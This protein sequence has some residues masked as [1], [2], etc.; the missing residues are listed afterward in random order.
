SCQGEGRPLKVLRAALQASRTGQRVALA[1]VIA[2]DG[3]APR[4]AGA[5]MLVRLDGTIVGTVGGGEF[6]RQ[7]ILQALEA[8]EDRHPRRYSVHLTRDLGMCCG[9]AMEA[10]I[11]PLSTPDTLVIYGAGHVGQATCQAAVPLGFDVTVVDEREEWLRP[12]LLPGATLLDGSP[13]KMLDQVPTGPSSHHLVVTHSHQLDQALIEQLLPMSLAWLGMIGSRAKVAKFL[14]RLRATGM[15]P[16]LFTRLCAPVGLDLGAETP[17]EIAV[18]IVAELIR[19]RRR[20]ARIPRP[21]SAIP[22]PARG[23]PGIAIATA[24]EEIESAN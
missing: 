19:I 21:L 20:C 2:V 15:D 10:Y 17:Q 8:M 16:G 11:E 5:R 22:L 3:S 24:M 1:T 7:V 6:E 23:E 14:V 4:V 9:G 12:E 13:L 18:S